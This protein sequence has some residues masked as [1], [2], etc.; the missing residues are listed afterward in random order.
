MAFGQNR[1]PQAPS[2]QLKASAV[3]SPTI[4]ESTELVQLCRRLEGVDLIGIDTEFV[5]EDTFYPELCLIQ[6][7][8]HNECTVIDAMAIQDIKPFW[9]L[10][11]Q[12][13]HVTIL[14]AGREE[15]NFIQRAVKAV[16]KRLFDV[17]IAAGFCSNEYPSAYGSVVSK[18]LGHKPAKGEQRTDWRKRPLTS[19]QINYALEDVRYLLPLY[20]KLSDMLTERER[21]D[22]FEE[23]IAK[24]QGE[25]I[26][27]LDRKD[28]RRVSGIGKLGPRNLAIVRELWNWRYEEARRR[29]QP[30]KRLLRDDLIVELAKRKVDNP[31][32]IMAIRG[33]ERSSVKRKADALAEC[34]RRGLAAP[35]E[36]M[37]KSNRKNTPSQLNLLGQFLAPA[38]GTICHRAEI[39]ASMVGTASDVREL[40]AYHMGYAEDRNGMLPEL[41]E[42]W[43]AELVGNLIYDL[44]DGKKSIRIANAKHTDPL[45]FE[46]TA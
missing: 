41:A 8:T 36:H 34:V 31:E 25:V 28:W 20:K 19:A 27:A 14:H 5:S 45:T 33:M 18:F 23:E 11:V 29:N 38:L 39:A 32:Q 7:A 46:N 17:Q 4:T 21:L 10:L 42:G 35:V 15:L 2:L 30:Q 12:G 44:L 43:R 26:N 22:W 9:Q 6:V 1:F 37:P 24:W 3:S 16:P 13:D 40:V